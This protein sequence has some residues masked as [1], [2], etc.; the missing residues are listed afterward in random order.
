MGDLNGLW[1]Q[2]TQLS[3]NITVAGG[4]DIITTIT[5]TATQTLTSEEAAVRVANA[6][7]AQ[8]G[9]QITAGHTGDGNV[10][11]SALAPVTAL[12]IVTWAV[13]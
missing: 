6:L 1:P 8:W 5:Q 4:D 12:T 3:I 13:V 10:T 9:Y 2:G 7:N 11:I